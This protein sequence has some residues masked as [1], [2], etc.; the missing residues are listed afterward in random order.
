[1]HSNVGGGYADPG[2]SDTAFDWMRT[3]AE[4]CGLAFDP[5][6]LENAIRPGALGE[7]RVSNDGWYRLLPDYSRPL[8]RQKN[9]NE[10]IAP[11]ALE[12]HEKLPD[13]RPKNLLKWLK[14]RAA[15]KVARG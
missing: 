1:V 10:E 13:Y 4:A 11:S 8:C 3:K 6:Y 5:A 7:L 9:G 14:D 15:L 12:R 2:L